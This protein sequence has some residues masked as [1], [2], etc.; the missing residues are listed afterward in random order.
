M[1][2]KLLSKDESLPRHPACILFVLEVVD[3][4]DT[5]ELKCNA[6][7]FLWLAVCEFE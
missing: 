7:G 1:L 4:V 5:A 6:A 2:D 3:A